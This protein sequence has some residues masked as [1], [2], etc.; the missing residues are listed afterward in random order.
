MCYPLK[1]KRDVFNHVAKRFWLSIDFGHRK[2]NSTSQLTLLRSEAISNSRWVRNL[3]VATNPGSRTILWSSR[4]PHSAVITFYYAPITT[5]V[6]HKEDHQ[7]DYHG[8]SKPNS[9][10]PSLSPSCVC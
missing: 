8:K 6:P 9:M 10:V 7:E 2:R 5:Y 1:Q 4:L 3:H